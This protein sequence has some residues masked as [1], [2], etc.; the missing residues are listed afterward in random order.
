MPVYVVP[1]HHD[2]RDTLLARF[3]SQGKHSMPGFMQYV[4]DDFPVRLISLDTHVPGTDTGELCAERLAWLEARL[5]E[6]PS[7]PTLLLLHHPSFD[8]GL[9]VL[10]DPI[11]A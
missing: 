8:T 3:E 11:A 7:K 6:A 10:D 2:R 1:G 9:R 5:T 4:V